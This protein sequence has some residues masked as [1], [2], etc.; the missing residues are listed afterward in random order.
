MVVYLMIYNG[1]KKGETKLIKAR[2]RRVIQG[3]DYSGQCDQFI[4]G[5][6]SI[7]NYITN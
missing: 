6:K 4:D 3:A 1:L 5:K 7:R 2:I